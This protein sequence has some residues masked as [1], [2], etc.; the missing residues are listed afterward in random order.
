MKDDARL[1]TRTCGNICMELASHRPINIAVVLYC[2]LC[3]IFYGAE[4]S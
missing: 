3:I 4:V 1:F 2:I